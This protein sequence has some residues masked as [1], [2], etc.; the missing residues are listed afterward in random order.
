MVAP[1]QTEECSGATAMQLQPQQ[2]ANTPMQRQ[3]IAIEAVQEIAAEA[4]T[5]LQQPSSALPAANFAMQISAV[6]SSAAQKM[7]SIATHAASWWQRRRRNHAENANCMTETAANVDGQHAK[8]L[9]STAAAAAART[10][11]P[12]ASSATA[13]AA[14]K[15]EARTH[16]SACDAADHIL[17]THT[18]HKTPRTVTQHHGLLRNQSGWGSWSFGGRTWKP[19]ASDHF[20]ARPW[21]IEMMEVE[22]GAAIYRN[23][24]AEGT[25]YHAPYARPPTPHGGRGLPHPL[26]GVGAGTDRPRAGPQQLAARAYGLMSSSIADWGQCGRREAQNTQD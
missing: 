23:K 4:Q 10:E 26:R 17:H 24:R 7:Q 2:C 18:T 14:D 6:A 3:H 19:R 12:E 25:P 20:T 21:G 22:A 13:A 16:N 11:Q 1:Q 8:E 9:E 15:K 5:P